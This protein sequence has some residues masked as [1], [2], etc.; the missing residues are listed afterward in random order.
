M[1]ETLSKLPKR[2]Q[3]EDEEIASESEDGNRLKDP[4]LEEHKE[5]EQ[6]TAE[7]RRLKMTKQV[8]REFASERN[9]DFFD[10]LQSKA[11]PEE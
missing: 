6:I 4:F 8:I 3:K 9:E 7:E 10:A 2:K 5:P 11:T 1:K